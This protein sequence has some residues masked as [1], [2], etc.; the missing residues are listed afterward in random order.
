VIFSVGYLLARRLL[1]CL[2]VMARREVS[3][4]V[5]LLVLWHENAVLRR[6][7]GRVRYQ[8]TRLYALIVIE[9]G[10]RRVHL[11]GITANPGGAWTHKQPATS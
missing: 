7:A 9:H 4:D 10:I 2:M 5:V 1:G 3:K 11:A 6:Q 8:P